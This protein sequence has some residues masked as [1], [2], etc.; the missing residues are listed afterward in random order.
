[1]VDGAALLTTMFHG[2]RATGAWSDERAANLLDGAAPFYRTYECADGKYL[3]VGAIEPKF[4]AAVLAGLGLDSTS[5]PGQFDQAAWPS[6]TERFA[7]AFRSRDR[8]EWVAHFTELDACVAPVNDLGE[9]AH[10][11]HLMDRN[12]FVDVA[13]IVQPAPAPRFGSP[14]DAPLAPR[15]PGADTDAVLAALGFSQAEIIR[16]RSDDVVA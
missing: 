3:A 9:A 10:D 2:M 13:G 14:T 5:L 4:Y 12:G 15:A 11:D 16:L 8:D 6:L 1:M 7:T